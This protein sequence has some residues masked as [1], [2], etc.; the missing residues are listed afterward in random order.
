MVYLWVIHMASV[1]I[2]H[3]IVRVHLGVCLSVWECKPIS[4]HSE[5]K[6]GMMSHLRESEH[7]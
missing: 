2:W 1:Y 4:T 7:V 6:I 5:V 3:L